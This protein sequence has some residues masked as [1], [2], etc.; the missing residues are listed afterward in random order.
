MLRRYNGLI[1]F[2]STHQALRMESILDTKNIDF[3]IRPI[4][5]SISAGCGLAIEFYLT[6]LEMIQEVMHSHEIV[7]HSLYE[8]LDKAYQVLE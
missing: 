5:P 7:Y 6:E 8:K 1:T 3:D 2:D 4:P